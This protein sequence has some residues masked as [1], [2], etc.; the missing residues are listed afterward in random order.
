MRILVLGGSGFAGGHIA[1]SASLKGWE[2]IIT[3]RNSSLLPANIQKEVLDITK[4][5][6]AQEFITAVKPDVVVNCAAITSID[7]AEQE[8]EIA[9]LTNTT[10]A[11]SIA[12]TCSS[13]GIKHI[14]FSSDAIFDGEK[15]SYS[16]EDMTIPV[17]HYGHTKAEAEK[18]I[19]KDAPD[20]IILRV[21]L[22]LGFR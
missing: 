5:K 12:R 22:V 6:T 19:R 18:G 10:A 9:T 16:E 8:K 11:V 17:N 2:V 21:S 7:L 15:A 13:A 3:S 14:F 4:L 1:Y 20:S